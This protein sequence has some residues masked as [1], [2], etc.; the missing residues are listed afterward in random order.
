MFNCVAGSKVPLIIRNPHLATFYT[1]GP[2]VYD[3]THLGHAS[4]YVKLDIIQRLLRDYF[5]VPL[6]TAM[7]I[8]DIDDKII[9]RAAETGRPWQDIA[10][11]NELEFWKCL[12]DLG[13]EAPNCKVRVTDHMPEINSFIQK[14]LD[15]GHAYQ[16]SDE[17]VYFE[18]A[19][20]KSH[21]KV[22]GTMEN[23]E[24]V[25]EKPSY[26]KRASKDFVL[27]KAVNNGPVFETAFGAG[28]PGWHIECSAMAS[29][30]FGNCV[31]FHGGGWDLKFPH[32]ENEETQSCAY[33]ETNQ[34]VNY[35]LHTGQ[36]RLQ[37][38]VEKMSKSLG[39]TIGVADFLSRYSS[40]H[41]RMFCLLSNYRSNTEFSEEAMQPAQ[42]TLAKF[43][44][45]LQDLQLHARGQKILFAD[46]H[47][48]QGQLTKTISTYDAS[49]RD[50]FDTA[51]ALKALLELISFVNR[52]Q[53]DADTKS[54]AVELNSGLFSLSERFVRTQL[55][56]LGL[57]LEPQTAATSE[58]E[59][60]DAVVESV[61]EVRAELRRRGKS[62]NDKSLF[63]LA[64]YIRKQL[65]GAG[66]EI[67]DRDK[68]KT[69]WSRKA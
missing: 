1:C 48:F 58:S 32:H 66:L 21:G 38:A 68:L 9:R 40:D 55:R 54:Q 60:F 23:Q 67:K 63:T 44:T 11:E 25:V 37:G 28:R 14:L 69:T 47:E 16:A 34:W 51:R 20:H 3:A 4:C 6:L 50:D 36:L 53:R 30:L 7:N 46:N 24:E 35:W 45:F 13:V 43:G 10:R 52:S 39:N 26:I 57:N 61:L 41:F 19:T 59:S 2:T 62:S 65:A 56:T 5:K 22:S 31:D 12:A 42:R 18:C 64:D 17:S 27:W 8:T 49:L 29:K 15:K 33:H